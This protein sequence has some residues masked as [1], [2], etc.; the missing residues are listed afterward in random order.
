MLHQRLRFGRIVVKGHG[1]IQNRPVA[2]LPQVGGGA[3][4]EPEWVIVEAAAHIPVALFRQGLI[5]VV[6]AAILK[7]GGGNVQ[8]ALPCPG[9]DH[10]DKRTEEHTSELQS[11]R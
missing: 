11:P 1:L 6:G 2:G 9:G 10:V 5:L 7:L 3:G 4:N 8:N